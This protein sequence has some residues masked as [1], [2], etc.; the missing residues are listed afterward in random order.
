MLFSPSLVSRLVWNQ[1]SLVLHLH[2]HWPLLH[3]WSL[4]PLPSH[5]N[6]K[7][8][9]LTL[10]IADRFVGK[11]DKIYVSWETIKLFI[12]VIFRSSL[13]LRSSQQPKLALSF[14][15]FFRR[16]ALAFSQLVSGYSLWEPLT[17]RVLTLSRYGSVSFF[18]IS[19]TI[20]RFWDTDSS[21]V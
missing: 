3:A 13:N 15:T 1:S 8:R 16:L 17:R 4:S 11:G 6:L 5:K 12:T 19:F 9:V 21:P 18:G 7:E 10:S 20:P 2:I 14:V